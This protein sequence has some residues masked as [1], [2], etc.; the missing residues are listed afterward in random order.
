M[1]VE[2]LRPHLYRLQVQ[3]GAW[4]RRNKSLVTFGRLCRFERNSSIR[5]G[6]NSCLGFGN[7][8]MLRSGCVLD[9]G[10]QG[11]LV[12]ADE[13]EIR[14]YAIIECG[15]RVFIGRR[16]VI[17]AYNWLQG[18]GEIDIGDDVIIGPGVRI[19]STSHDISDPNQPFSR[20]P[21]IAQ[22]VQIGSNVWIGADVIILGGVRVGKNVVIGA[23]SLVN[24]DLDDGGV[25]VGTPA[26]RVK[27]LHSTL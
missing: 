21:L 5:L 2:V 10:R 18:S 26:R 14:H 16:S 20:Q 17:G 8:V 27:E 15:G 13:V 19:I 12:L 6:K 9:L 24:R 4:L 25:Y 7:K 22:P 23:G 11:N 3:L 1:S